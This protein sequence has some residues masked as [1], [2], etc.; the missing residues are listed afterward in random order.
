[1]NYL[2]KVIYE[3]HEFPELLALRGHDVTFFHYPEASTEPK[4]SWKATRA[5]IRGRAYPDAR[6]HLV[7]PPTWGGRPWERY[8]APLLNMPSLRRE[9]R[10]GDYDVVVLY[11]V[12]TTGWQTILMAKSYGVPV[13]FRALD[14][15][16]MIRRSPLSALIH[17]AERFIYRNANLISSNNGAMAE[18]CIETSKRT[19]PTVVDLPPIDFS[20]FDSTD[21]PGLRASLTLLEKDRVILYMGSFFDFSG[22]DVFVRGIAPALQEHADLKVVLVGG[23]DLDQP[24][25]E[26]VGVLGLESR[27]IFT[28]IVPYSALPGYL[29]IADVAINPFVPQ[30]LTH[31]ALPHKV[32]QYMAAGVPV[33]S[34]SLTGLRGVL[35]DH[36][37]VTWVDGPDEVADAALRLAYADADE[38]RAVVKTQL[39]CI[40]VTFSKEEAVASLERTLERAVSSMR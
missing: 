14:V 2:N 37:G 27:V 5:V 35:G 31:L 36:S 38:R 32:L 10:H 18:Y 1:M 40:E 22:L 12:P 19:L 24:L 23:G 34:S 33:V 29:K 11:A 7:T 26:L 13:V 6:L 4:V 28:G 25:R 3:M 20:H 39:E 21:V 8:F 9:L 30:L 16:H 15:S 17:F